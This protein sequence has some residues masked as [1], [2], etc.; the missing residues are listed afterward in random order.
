MRSGDIL[1]VDFGI[2]VGSTAALV[3]PAI[4]VTADQTLASYTTTFHV[5][6]V[7][8][9]IERAWS[10]DV[11]LDDHLFPLPS[12]AQ[13]HLCTVIDT[14]QVLDEAGINVGSVQLAQIRSIVADLLD[15]S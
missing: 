13:C 8:T 9:K 2:P 15:V 6:P 11:R 14:S 7:A 3:R 1:R 12:A 10:T 4:V 5:V